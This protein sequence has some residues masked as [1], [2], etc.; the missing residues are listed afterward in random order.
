MVVAGNLLSPNGDGLNDSWKIENIDLYP[1]NEV[2]VFDKTG[3]VIYSKKGYNNEWNGTVAGSALSQDTY[4]YIIDFGP[5]LPK[6]KGF[7]TMLNN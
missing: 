2:M 6:K 1:N 7:I 3:R 5:G 4:Y